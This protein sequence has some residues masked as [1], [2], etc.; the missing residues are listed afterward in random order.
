MVIMM[1]RTIK[2]RIRFINNLFFLYRPFARRLPEFKF[3]M[4]CLRAVWTGFLMTFFEMFDIP[5][6]WPVLL[7]YFLVLF[8]FTMKKQIR[9]MIKH[10]YLPFS[11]GKAKYQGKAPSK[12]SK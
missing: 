4:A 6:F 8:F 2:I 9:H 11:F 12:D 7:F 10:R 5:V 1:M 3:W